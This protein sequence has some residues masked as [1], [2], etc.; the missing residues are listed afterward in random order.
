MT[1]PEEPFVFPRTGHAVRNRTVL[2]AMTN[3][4]SHSNGVL[5]DDEINWLL[6]RADGGFGII[7]TAATHVTEEGQG[8]VGEMGVWGDH[9]IDR[10]RELTSGIRERGALSL[11]QIFHGGMRAPEDITGKQ[12]LSAS[13][14]ECKESHSGKSREATGDEIDHLIEAFGD[15]AA[16]CAIAGFDGIE[17]HG[18]H[19]Y[20][21]CQFLGEQTNRRNDKWGGDCKSRTNFLLEIIRNV[22]SKTPENFIVGVR[23]SPEYHQIGVRIQDTITQA[24]KIVE[25]GIDFLHISCWDC[26][27]PSSE[28]PEDPRRITE[29]FSQELGQ[30]VPLISTGAIWSRQDTIDVLSQG[31]TLIGVGRAAIGHADWAANIANPNYSPPRPPFSVMH[32]R[33]Q[34]LSDTFVDYMRNWKEFVE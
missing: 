28:F 8:W 3:K 10:L 34:G 23:L 18:A 25:E 19:G 1:Q 32:L 14:N 9:H 12:P 31:A 11:A 6:K 22:K 26:F 17:L 20:L 5:S 24:K 7:T 4:Q 15:A 13:V 33:E 2:A 21:I 27:T 29:W 30:A 16:R